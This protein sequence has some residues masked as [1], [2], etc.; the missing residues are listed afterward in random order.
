ML[1]SLNNAVN[2]PII[3][4]KKLNEEEIFRIVESTYTWSATDN[5]EVV[6]NNIANIK[7]PTIGPSWN[8][9][10]VTNMSSMFEG[11]DAFNQSITNWNTGNVID[12]NN[13]FNSANDFNGDILEWNSSKVTDMSYM[14]KDAVSFNKHIDTKIIIQ[15]SKVENNQLV[16][17][18]AH[19]L[20]HGD[21][22]Y[23]QQ[24]ESPITELTTNT[25]YY[26]I[27]RSFIEKSNTDD[28]YTISLSNS[29]NGS[30]LTLSD[31]NSSEYFTITGN[32][33]WDVV[34]VTNMNA[35]F[36]NSTTFNQNIRNWNVAKVT[37]ITNMFL[38]ANVFDQDISKWTLSSVTAHENVFDNSS[39]SRAHILRFNDTNDNIL[40]KGLIGVPVI[41]IVN[42]TILKRDNNNNAVLFPTD[43]IKGYWEKAGDGVTDVGDEQTI[44]QDTIEYKWGNDGITWTNNN[45]DE[46]TINVN[47]SNKKMHLLVEF[48]DE[49]D[50]TLTKLGNDIS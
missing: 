17:N 15:G 48:D 35:M 47:D 10:K 8:T 4:T 24:G 14:F 42:E 12:M 32:K 28:K 11:A 20:S 26:V 29:L 6:I 23:Y 18:S 41:E 13:M 2:Y 19:N 37:N 50:Y 36:H 45:T 3:L 31:N 40:W 5:N 9:V 27:Y 16:F 44:K 38:G 46:Y 1:T 30:P 33:Q 39:L 22:I 21:M 25:A 34:K 49:K 7:I 43:G